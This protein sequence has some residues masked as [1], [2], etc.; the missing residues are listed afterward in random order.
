MG[1]SHSHIGLEL[2]IASAHPI[3]FP[4]ELR[5]GPMTSRFHNLRVEGLVN[6]TRMTTIIPIAA[7]AEMPAMTPGD[8]LDL[9]LCKPVAPGNAEGVFVGLY[10]LEMFRACTPQR[11]QLQAKHDL[12]SLCQLSYCRALRYYF[13]R[14]AM[15]SS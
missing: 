12:G 1:A 3:L 2:Q 15:S 14:I 9:F 7:P 10:C 8:R 4:E 5:P 6:R 11:S 13:R